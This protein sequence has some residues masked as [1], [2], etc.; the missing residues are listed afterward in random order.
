M[1]KPDIGSESRFLPT[2]PAFD[3][4][5]RGF[6]S[7]YRHPVWYGKTGVM[8]LPDAENIS[9]ICLFVLT[10]STDVTDTDTHTY[11]VIYTDTA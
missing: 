9:K 10:R 1:L 8:W 11:N 4:P 3:A 6:P 5:V 2:L 7:E